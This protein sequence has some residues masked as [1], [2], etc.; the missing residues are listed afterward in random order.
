MLAGHSVGEGYGPRVR[1]I[2]HG[3]TDIYRSD[4]VS[5]ALVD[6]EVPGLTRFDHHVV[7]VPKQAVGVVVHDADQG[8][9]LIYRHRFITDSWGY[10]IPAGSVEAGEDLAV[11]ASREV[12]EET[13]WRPG[14]LTPTVRFF[15]SNGLSDQVFNIFEASHAEYVGE[16]SDPSESERV[17]WLSLQRLREL[18]VAG[19]ITDGLSLTALSHWY[20]TRC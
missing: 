5:L 14:S 16:P 13:G 11:A 12:V 10:E 18:L 2:T 6:V 1:W 4:W 19:E 15:P 17:E 7:R 20:L 3:E 8:V 9:L